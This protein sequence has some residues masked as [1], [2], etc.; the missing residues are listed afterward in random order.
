MYRDGLP[1]AKYSNYA[2]LTILEKIVK[3]DGKPKIRYP[4]S[5]KLINRENMSD[6][7]IKVVDGII[8]FSN[9]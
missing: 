3:S 8:D 5:K 9:Y 7:N 4:L 1:Y 2:E 6:E